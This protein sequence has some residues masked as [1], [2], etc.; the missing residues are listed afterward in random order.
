MAEGFDD[1][2]SHSLA[3]VM[4]KKPE[5]EILDHIETRIKDL[6]E[7]AEKAEYASRE[8]T[9]IVAIIEELESLRYSIKKDLNL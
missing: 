3:D 1:T 2:T 6:R 8:H 5:E 9:T 4:D 7:D